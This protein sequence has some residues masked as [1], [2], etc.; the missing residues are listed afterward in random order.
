MK[1]Q[2]APLPADAQQWY[3]R[4]GAHPVTG[5]RG[6]EDQDDA[7]IL[8]V[9]AW[10]LT[11]SEQIEKSGNPILKREPGQLRIKQVR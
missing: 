3:A 2:G 4:Q 8:A 1:S 9:T 5:E 7:D 10:A 6:D 11:R